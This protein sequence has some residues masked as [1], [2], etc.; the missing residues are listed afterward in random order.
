MS[1]L[2][3]RETSTTIKLVA[4]GSNTFGFGQL[5]E[6]AFAVANHDV[7]LKA[8]AGVYQQ[9]PDAVFIRAG[10]GISSLPDLEGRK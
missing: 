7:P 10:S 4:N 9:M 6:M 8:I 2:D 5:S 1:I 3:G